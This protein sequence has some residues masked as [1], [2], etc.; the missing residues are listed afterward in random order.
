MVIFLRKRRKNS[1]KKATI[2][3]AYNST[4]HF[5]DQR[6]LTIQFDKYRFLLKNFKFNNKIILDAGCGTGLLYEYIMNSMNQELVDNMIYIAI[7]ISQNMLKAFKLK[8]NLSKQNKK[9]NI[10]LILADLENM[11][12]RSDI[13]HGIFSLTSLQNL[14]NLKDGIVE[15]YRASKNN[16]ELRISILKKE[17]KFEELSTFLKSMIKDLN[18]IDRESI[19]DMIFQG[20]T[21]KK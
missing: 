13:F 11:P 8:M 2:I 15:L 1:D 5:Y 20:S 10:N 17:L 3:R 16:A 6:Y 14:P 21:F 7:D 18:I 12:I 9:H 4:S 19:E